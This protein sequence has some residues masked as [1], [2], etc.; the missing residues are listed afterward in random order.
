MKQNIQSRRAPA[1]VGPYSPAIRVGDLVFC[2]GQ[3]PI[4]PATGNLVDGDITA[5]TEQVMRNLAA[6]CEAAG[7][8]LDNVVKTTVYMVDLAEF[9]K[10]NEVYGKYFTEPYP[11]RATAQASALPKGARIE[12]EAIAYL[13]A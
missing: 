13:G 1:A 11:A 9:A 6:L 5:Q 12:I 4:D 10:V 7:A 8:N 3:I 2:S